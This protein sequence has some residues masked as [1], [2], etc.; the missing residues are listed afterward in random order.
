[1]A[2][3]LLLVFVNKVNTELQSRMSN[4]FFFFVV[5]CSLSRAGLVTIFFLLLCY[6]SLLWLSLS[7]PPKAR[8]M[9][10]PTCFI[11][12]RELRAIIRCSHLPRDPLLT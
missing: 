10:D 9:Y 3:N 8:M 11:P 12:Q 7:L 2:S 5:I 1:M 4:A 6:L